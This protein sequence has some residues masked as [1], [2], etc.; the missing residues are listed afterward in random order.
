MAYAVKL[1]PQAV[2]D[3]GAAYEWYEEQRTGLGEEFLVAVEDAL[4]FLS[5]NPKAFSEKY[6]KIRA[7]S[8]KRFPYSVYYRPYKRTVWVLAVYHQSRNPRHWRKKK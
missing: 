5:Y 7:C 8:L 1:R 2:A 4:D 6:P 3:V